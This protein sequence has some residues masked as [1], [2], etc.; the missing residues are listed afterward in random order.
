M[1][2]KI[3]KGFNFAKKTQEE[4]CKIEKNCNRLSIGMSNDYVLALKAGATDLRI[5]TNLFEKRNEK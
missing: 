3:I 5:G 4:M 1:K 2:K